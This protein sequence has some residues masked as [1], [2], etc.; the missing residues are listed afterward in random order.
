MAKV[1]LLLNI[2]IARLHQLNPSLQAYLDH[3]DSYMAPK[4]SFAARTMSAQR[5][6]ARV[7]CAE[8][9]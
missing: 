5:S 2:V 3:A 6:R 8:A 7:L 9:A 1:K 4:Q